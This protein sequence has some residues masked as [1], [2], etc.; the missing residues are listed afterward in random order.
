MVTMKEFREI[1]RKKEEGVA[2]SELMKE[3]AIDYAEL[4]EILD[5]AYM[6]NIANEREYE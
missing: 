3:Y 1:I 5:N 6:R 2:N 4:R